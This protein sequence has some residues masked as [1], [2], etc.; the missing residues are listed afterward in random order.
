[1]WSLKLESQS[2]SALIA[3]FLEPKRNLNFQAQPG[4]LA[5]LAR[6]SRLQRECRGFEP[7]TA[8]FQTTQT[9]RRQTLGNKETHVRRLPDVRILLSRLREAWRCYSDQPSRY[10]C[11]M[12]LATSGALVALRFFASHSIFLPSAHT[13]KFPRRIVSVKGPA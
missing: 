9:L 13:A 6:A 5:Q 2:Y 8:H 7:L 1:M 10:S 12:M 11:L 3:S 4:P